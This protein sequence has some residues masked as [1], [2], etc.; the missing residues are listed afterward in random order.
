MTIRA[1]AAAML[2]GMEHTRVA[3]AMG[4]RL[5]NIRAAKVA[6]GGLAGCCAYRTVERSGKKVSEALKLLL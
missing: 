1:P 5:W 3:L 2:G 4:L 6:A